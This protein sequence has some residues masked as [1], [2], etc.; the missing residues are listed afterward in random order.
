MRLFNILS[1]LAQRKNVFLIKN[2]TVAAPETAGTFDVAS[3]Q[4]TEPGVYLVGEML[5]SSIGNDDILLVTNITTTGKY[6]T[7]ETTARGSM[8]SGGGV[9]ALALME[10]DAGDTVTGKVYQ[11]Q[12]WPAWNAR[13]SLFAIKLVGGVI[14]T[15]RRA[16]IA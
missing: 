15:L 3:I 2:A 11:G 10:L 16:V 13:M 14:N 12:G 8:N 4:V 5:Q 7:Q 1:A 9:A 6:L